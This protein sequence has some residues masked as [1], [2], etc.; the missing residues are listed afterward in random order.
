MDQTV[1]GRTN[2]QGLSALVAHDSLPVIVTGQLLHV[3]NLVHL[4]VG[5]FPT[6]KLAD[7]CFEARN[8]VA[9]VLVDDLARLEVDV[10]SFGNCFL[11]VAA[12][13]E[14]ALTLPT[15]DV[16]ESDAEAPVD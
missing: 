12:V 9:L 15:F 10:A 3:S 8:H 6:A 2:R 5:V 4:Q 13:I 14:E 7:A 16:R 1:A 11:L